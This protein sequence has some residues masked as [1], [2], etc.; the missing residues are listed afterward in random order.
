MSV[1]AHWFFPAYASSRPPPLI[2][3]D[4]AKLNQVIFGTHDAIPVR[5]MAAIRGVTGNT[6]GTVILIPIMMSELE[7]KSP[8]ISDQ[9][10]SGHVNS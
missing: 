3:G 4:N 5:L 9:V 7:T 6:N 1:T 2:S 8:P 10:R